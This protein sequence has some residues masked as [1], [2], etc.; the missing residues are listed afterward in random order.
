M[1]VRLSQVVS[2]PGQYM[3]AMVLRVGAAVDTSA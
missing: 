3:Y 2:T 1:L